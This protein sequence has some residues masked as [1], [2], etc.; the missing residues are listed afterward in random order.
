MSERFIGQVIIVDT[1]SEKTV[2]NI[3]PDTS[4]PIILEGEISGSRVMDV[5][6]N[7]QLRFYAPTLGGGRSTLLL[8]GNNSD[9][10]VGGLPIVDGAGGD[11]ALFPGSPDVDI[12]NKADATILLQGNSSSIRC[13][14][15]GQNRGG[16]IALFPGSSNTDDIGTP[17]ALSN[18]TVYLNG[19]NGTI[20]CG[21]GNSFIEGQNANGSL[22]LFRAGH[23]NIAG[24]E[25]HASI[26]ADAGTLD[27]IISSPNGDTRLDFSG[28]GHAA[29]LRIGG[30]GAG[31]NLSLFNSDN[32]AAISMGGD[33]GN[34][35][36]RHSDKDGAEGRVLED[37]LMFDGKEAN[38]FIGGKGADGD[39]HLRN[40]EGKSTII[41]EGETG[42]IVM[43]NADF[44]EDF[45]VLESIVST[46]EPGTL[47]VLNEEGKLVKSS[48]A[49]D[50]KVAGVISGAGKY[51]PAIIM[52]KQSNSENRLPIAMMGKV[53][54][55]V[56]ASFGSIEVGDLLTSSPTPGYAMK[57]DDPVKAFG[58]VIGKALGKME[59]KKGLIPI[60]VSLQ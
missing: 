54:C 16:E 15:G 48:K 46:V 37:R 2:V 6:S 10:L 43:V 55:H 13:G 49:Y 51:K 39:L 31:G 8:D 44:A 32:K 25:K 50:K 12:T 9:I 47:M 24:D 60:L 56:D 26:R 53:M 36:I 28:S 1:A 3:D 58:S 29:N 7:A 34:F 17:A 22:S 19:D 23:V 41:M 21:G 35:T 27:F 11:I 4:T 14:A 33:N 20:R 30:K 57:A 18:A 59:D 45:D 5:T 52:D 42:D 38:L 40:S